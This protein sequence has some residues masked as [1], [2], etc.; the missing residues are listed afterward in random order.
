M[1]PTIGWESLAEGDEAPNVDRRLLSGGS[2]ADQA[3]RISEEQNPP[4]PERETRAGG[5][6][7]D[8][9]DAF[10]SVGAE[11]FDITLTDAAGEKAGFRGHRSLEQLRTAMP[12]IL[13]EA[14]ERQHNV[15][16]RPRSTGATTADRDRA[17][18]QAGSS[19]WQPSAGI[20]AAMAERGARQRAAS[21]HPVIA[22][23]T[24]R[25]KRWAN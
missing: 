11:R 23:G 21:G 4:S 15:I 5:P 9:L 17:G 3:S 20:S 25:K 18:S 1:P 24:G 10:A 22:A 7:L 13:E 2:V 6:T 12:A 16:V 8:M 14:A 19:R